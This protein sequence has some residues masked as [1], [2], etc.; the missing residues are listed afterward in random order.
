MGS[1]I[2]AAPEATYSAKYPVILPKQQIITT[3]IIDS[4]HQRLL[5][6]NNENVHNEMRQQYFVASLR[7][8]IRKVSQNCQYCKKKECNT[9]TSDDGTTTRDR[10]TPRRLHA[11]LRT[12][13][14]IILVL[15][16]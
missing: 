15:W 13:E 1:R 14:L 11:H 3:L 2:E 5:H 8:L 10:L 9:Q 6:A 16:K 12:S 4:L 7:S